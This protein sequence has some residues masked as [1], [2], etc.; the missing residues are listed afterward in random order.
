M[1]FHIT[2]KIKSKH[3]DGAQ[4]RFLETGALPPEG[5]TMIGRWHSVS[6]RMGF[7]LAEASDLQPVATWLQQW[8]DLLAF[9]IE[10]V[11]NDKQSGQVLS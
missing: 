11:L 1:H 3:R 7:V 8:T 4:A 5:V 6:G 2:Y 9:D 10:P